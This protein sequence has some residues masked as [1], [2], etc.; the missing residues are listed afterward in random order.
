VSELIRV[1]MVLTS[2]RIMRVMA[3]KKGMVKYTD[4]EKGYGYILDENAKDPKKTILFEAKDVTSEIEELDE[5]SVV[6]YEEAENAT[7]ATKVSP[8]K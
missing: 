4:P 5:G 7:R 1:D 6:E 8:A 2:L 3:K